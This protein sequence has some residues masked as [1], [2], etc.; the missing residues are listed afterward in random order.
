MLDEQGLLNPALP[1]AP[2]DALILPMTEDPAPA[3]SL[4]QQLRAK[5]IRVQLYAEKKKF[6][7]KMTYADRLAVPYA[8]LLGE[9]EIAAGKCSVKNMISGEQV[10]LEPDAAA[11]HILQGLAANTG[12]II[13][14]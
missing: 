2:A 10:T 5:G 7:Q 8:V 9:D 4:A 12:A 1:S 3:I 14:E 6:K 11:E 13:L